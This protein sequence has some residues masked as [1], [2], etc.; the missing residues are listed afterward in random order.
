M[1]EDSQAVSTTVCKGPATGEPVLMKNL[2]WESQEGV[3][4]ACISKGVI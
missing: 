4:T 1:H 3:L 2:P